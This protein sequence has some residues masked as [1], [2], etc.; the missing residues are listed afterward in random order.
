MTLNMSVAF[1]QSSE[2]RK[3]PIDASAR[4]AH[5]G[6]THGQIDPGLLAEDHLPDSFGMILAQ[7]RGRDLRSLWPSSSSKS[8]QT[9][10]E[11]L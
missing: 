10:Q 11:S 9:F 5:V 8:V 2:L 3:V 7:A 4:T 1:P 6:G